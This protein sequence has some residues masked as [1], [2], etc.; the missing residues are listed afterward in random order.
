VSVRAA[1]VNAGFTLI[2]LVITLAIVL[3]LAS[4]A[5]PLAEVA[6]Q[7]SREHDLRR[8]LREIREAIDSY[9]AAVDAGR[10]AKTTGD[11][12]YPQTLNILVEGTVDTK[13]PSQTKIYFLRRIPRDPFSRDATLPAAATWSK[14]SY[15]SPPDKPQ[16]G[17]DVYDVYSRSS[18]TGLNGIPYR[19]W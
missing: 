11:S 17:D 15:A 19:E 12:G 6:V 5:L 7:R 4:V 2:E 13:T 14:R 9:K 8:A 3:V 18:V 1:Q 16:E 10:I